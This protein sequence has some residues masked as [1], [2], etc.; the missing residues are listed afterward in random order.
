VPSTSDFVVGTLQFKSI[1]WWLWLAPIVLLA[2]AT[3]RMPYGYYTFTRIVVCASAALIAYIS[4]KE[5]ENVISRLWAVMFGLIA[6][7]FNPLVPIY[8]KRATW[9]SIDIGIAAIFAAHLVIVRL[10]LFRR[11]SVLPPFS[12]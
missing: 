11:K 7:L 9:F 12:T 1:P 6:V 4:W 2:V 8:L 3:A 5:S 10:G